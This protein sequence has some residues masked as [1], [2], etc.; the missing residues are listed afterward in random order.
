MYE[1]ERRHG[2]AKAWEGAETAAFELRSGDALTTVHHRYD[3]VSAVLKKDGDKY[4]L[5]SERRR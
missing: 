2:A 3:R 1:Q 5:C 4:E